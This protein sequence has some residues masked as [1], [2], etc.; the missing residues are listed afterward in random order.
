M[1]STSRGALARRR[2]Y[3]AS[4]SRR[5]AQLGSEH[6]V[7]HAGQ[8]LAGR[9]VAEHF[10]A[11]RHLRALEIVEIRDELREQIAERRRAGVGGERPVEAE[12]QHVGANGRFELRP[13]GA[14]R[15]HGVARQLR[16]QRCDLR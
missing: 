8:H 16:P 3:S 12:P 15:L 11:E 6:A 7:D 10:A 4:W 2:A 9:A 14:V 1:A 13:H 5:A